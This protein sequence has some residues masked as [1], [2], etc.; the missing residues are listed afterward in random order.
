MVCILLSFEI[1]SLGAA[2]RVFDVIPPERLPFNYPDPPREGA[3]V[4]FPIATDGQGRCV[5]VRPANASTAAQSAVAALAQYLNLVTGAAIKVLRDGQPIP[6]GMAAIHVG[7]TTLGKAKPLE[8]P[9]LRYGESHFPNVGGSLVKTLNPRTLLIR[10][11]NDDATANGIVGFL[12]RYAGVR[13]YWPGRPGDLGDVIPRR[14]T[15]TVPEVEWRDWPYFFSRTFSLKPFPPGAR[16]MLDFYRRHQTL[17]SGENYN[18]WLPPEQYAQS[19]P[20]YFALVNDKRLQP[21]KESGASRWQPCVS[22]PEVG[23]IMGDAVARFFA[24]N[25]DAPGINFAINDG[26]GNCTCTNCQAMD[27]PNTDYSMMIGTSDRYVKFS[28]QICEHVARQH[29]T[30]WLVYLAYAAA[31]H[32][33]LTVKPHPR[34]VPVLTVSGSLFES[35]DAWMKA[36]AEQMGLY[37]HHDDLFFILPKLDVHQ[38]AKRIR[39][40]AGSGRARV[41]YMEM[42]NQWPFAD[43]V[44]YV[45]SELLWDPRRKVDELL[46]EYYEKFFG[47]AAAPMRRFH[48]ILEKGYE[49]WLASEGVP[50][51]YGLDVSSF[52]HGRSLEQFRVLTPEEATRAADELADANRLAKSDEAVAERVRLFDAMFKLQEMGVRWA[53]AAFRLREANVSSLEAARQVIADARLVHEVNRQMGDH[54]AGTLEQPPLKRFGLYRGYSR[55]TPYYDEMKSGEPGPE[56]LA[57]VSAGIQSA[58]GFLRTNL[59]PAKAA[60]WWRQAADSEKQPKLVAAFQT[61]ALRTEGGEMKNLVPDP[62]F[63][64]IGGKL[65]PDEFALDRDKVLDPDQVSRIGIHHWFAERSPYRCVLTETDAHSGK[66]AIMMEHCYRAR[67]SRHASARPGER[68]R[69]SVW[70]RRNEG[71]GRYKLEV[72]ARLSNK[73]YPVLASIPLSGPP[74]EWREYVAEVVAPPNAGTVSLKL[75]VNGQAADARCWIDDVFIGK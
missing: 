62:G 32:P 22:N 57:A 11:A 64:E 23:R 37:L 52:R 31:K 10:G 28:N 49:R 9:E 43:T 35:W 4:Y 21:D 60:A 25:P 6:A 26:G 54:I 14:P 40:A 75:Y 45:T 5:I 66:H 47:P 72:D 34:L 58:C 15:L 53:W 39:Y 17:P 30:K 7:D 50:H 65:A 69:V 61:A 51:S 20:E 44:P 70:F 46:D 73:T 1:S 74:G 36:G 56:L 18:R 33:P 68:F 71:Q 29:P 16:P 48:G 55:P 42:H 27:A 8:L 19:H 41:F 63:E 12:K 67:F 59:G 13:Q 3:A 2:E 38:I 24:E